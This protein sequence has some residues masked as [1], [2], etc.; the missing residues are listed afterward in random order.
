V[1]RFFNKQVKRCGGLLFGEATV[2][3]GTKETVLSRTR[4]PIRLRTFMELSLYLFEMSNV[5]ESRKW[6]KVR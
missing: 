1:I 5:L 4:I 3:G 6:A 2:K